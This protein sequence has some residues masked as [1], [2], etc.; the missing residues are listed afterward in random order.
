M[1][2][3]RLFKVHSLVTVLV[4][5]HEHLSRRSQEH[6]Q[7]IFTLYIMVY[8]KQF[9]FYIN[10]YI[11]KTI[12][13]TPFMRLVSIHGSDEHILI[14]MFDSGLSGFKVKIKIILLEKIILKFFLL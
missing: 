10:Y 8:Y 6:P 7:N 1:I 4:I 2:S 14:L 12:L 9:F 5:V 13:I 11:R 3:I